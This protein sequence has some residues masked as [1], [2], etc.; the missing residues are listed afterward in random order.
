M[1]SITVA[2]NYKVIESHTER[3]SNIKILKIKSFKYKYN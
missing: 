3:V 2:L 1:F